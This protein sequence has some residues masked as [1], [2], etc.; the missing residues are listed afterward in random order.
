[1]S[2]DD[3]SKVNEITIIG[4][5]TSQTRTRG[6]ERDIIERTVEVTKVRDTFTRFLQ[7]L[8]EIIDVKVP[9]VGDFELDEVQFNAEISADGDFK[10]LGTGVGIEATSGVT[11]TLRRKADLSSTEPKAD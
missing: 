10:L 1:M 7:G 6:R 9:T 5:S 8:S 11:F 4:P 3:T 2:N